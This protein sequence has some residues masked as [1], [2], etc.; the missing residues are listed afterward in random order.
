M[1]NLRPKSELSHDVRMF[2]SLRL[3]TREIVFATLEVMYRMH[4]ILL[5]CLVTSF[6]IFSCKVINIFNYE[7][8]PNNVVSIY[9]NPLRHTFFFKLRFRENLYLDVF[10]VEYQIKQIFFSNFHVVM[11]ELKYPQ[12]NIFRQNGFV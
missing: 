9:I 1:F 7:I 3:C 11:S 8:Y 5:F 6:N 4:Y 2:R 10:G 12:V